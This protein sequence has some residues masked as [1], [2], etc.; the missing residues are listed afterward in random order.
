VNI[1]RDYKIEGSAASGAY[2]IV[3]DYRDKTLLFLQHLKK[4]LIVCSTLPDQDILAKGLLSK[5]DQEITGLNTEE[6]Y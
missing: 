2:K 4:K 6:F 5:N 1:A 3:E